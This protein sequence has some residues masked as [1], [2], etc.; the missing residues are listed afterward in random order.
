MRV[1]PPEYISVNA[2]KSS[3]CPSRSSNLS[4]YTNSGKSVHKFSCESVTDRQ[5]Y[6]KIYNIN[7]DMNF[8][9]TQIQIKIV[10][11][12]YFNLNSLK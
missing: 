11:I 2:Q 12:D 9:N 10:F 8:V 5:T 7:M 4:L 3:L 1:A 6:F